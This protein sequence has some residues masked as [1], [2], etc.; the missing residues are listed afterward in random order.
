MAQNNSI[1]VCPDCGAMAHLHA[2]PGKLIQDWYCNKCGWSTW[3]NKSQ[4]FVREDRYLIL[5]RKD[6]AAAALTKLERIALEEI[7][8]K[9][10]SIRRKR[11]APHMQGVVVEVDW[12]EYEQ[13]WKMIERRMVTHES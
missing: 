11:K 1:Q 3:K 9:V 2:E 13:V 5:K 7:C 6:L 4:P 12:P 8:D 10:E